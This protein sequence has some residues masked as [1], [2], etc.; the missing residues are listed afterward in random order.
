MYSDVN[1]ANLCHLVAEIWNSSF[2]RFAIFR[3]QHFENGLREA[4][5]PKIITIKI[6]ITSM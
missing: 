4:V 5:N 3:G 2:L 1:I 6:L